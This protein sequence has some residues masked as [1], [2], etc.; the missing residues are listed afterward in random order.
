MWQ[1]L[2]LDGRLATRNIYQHSPA[3]S[4]DLETGK[5]EEA[6]GGTMA[7]LTLDQMREEAYRL[8]V[9][10]TEPCCVPSIEGEEVALLQRHQRAEIW[11]AGHG[12]VFGDEVQL[13][14]SNG[15]RY[16][17]TRSGTSGATQPAFGEGGVSDGTVVW[18][19][20]GL[21]YQ[22]VYDVRA[23][24][25][26]AWTI[27]AARASHLVTTSAGNSRVEA[28]LLQAQCRARATEFAPLV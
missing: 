24:A 17:C 27:K 21:A 10:H 11:T 13:Y 22:N 15:Y 26:E 25:H 6:A 12:Y 23:A 8:M 4:Q 16:F 1:G 14:P 2:A 7:D 19:M 18:Q 20:C 9:L 5:E 28:S 3:K